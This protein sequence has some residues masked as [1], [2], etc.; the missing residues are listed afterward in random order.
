MILF[1]V[2]QARKTMVYLTVHLRT[3]IVSLLITLAELKYLFPYWFRTNIIR[4][5]LFEMPLRT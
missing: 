4:I 5:F 3:V 2:L 1:Y